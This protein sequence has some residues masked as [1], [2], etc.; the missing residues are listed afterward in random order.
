MNWS[1]RLLGCRRPCFAFAHSDN[2][3]TVPTE[4]QSNDACCLDDTPVAFEGSVQVSQQ[5][6]G[7]TALLCKIH[8][9]TPLFKATMSL[10]PS[11]E[12]STGTPPRPP[13]TASTSDPTVPPPYTS[14]P[15]SSSS[16]THPAESID[17]AQETATHK[18]SIELTRSMMASPH[19]DVRIM[20]AQM[21]NR[22]V[23]AGPPPYWPAD[24]IQYA[25]C[26]G[27]SPK[28]R[29]SLPQGRRLACDTHG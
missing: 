5:K 20:G 3:E 9:P 27:E 24:R 6:Q 13:P 26:A 19:P 18:D 4:P 23:Q 25:Q 21:V 17:A 14:L 15:S 22:L 28:G 2:L 8:Q 7:A 10:P 11:K 12:S 29:G 16:S 1:P